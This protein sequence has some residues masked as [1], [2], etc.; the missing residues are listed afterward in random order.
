[1]VSI[2]DARVVQNDWT[3]RWQNRLLQ[4]PCESS[5]VVEPGQAV[6]LCE[7]RDGTLRVFV[8]EVELRWSASRRQADASKPQR[9]GRGPTGSSQGQKPRADHPWR[10]KLWE[11]SR[12]S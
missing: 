4:L 10:G 7:Q 9:S 5:A 11:A 12:A 3:V 8:G 1:V 6:T 2:Q